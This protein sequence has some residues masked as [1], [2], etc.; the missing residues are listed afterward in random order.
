MMKA[1]A[2]A[3]VYGRGRY[4]SQ[5]SSRN[6]L[7][8]QQRQAMAGEGRPRPAAA[9]AAAAAPRHHA[10]DGG[11]AAPHHCLRLNRNWRTAGHWTGQKGAN[12]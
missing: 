3:G 2:A 5:V 9:A 12:W 10:H 11:R 6:G 7:P 4:S 8:A 1:G